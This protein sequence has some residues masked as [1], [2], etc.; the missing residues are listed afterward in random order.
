MN[1]A[2]AMNFIILL[3]LLSLVLIFVISEG[4]DFTNNGWIK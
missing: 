2:Q 4:L 3:T 1:H